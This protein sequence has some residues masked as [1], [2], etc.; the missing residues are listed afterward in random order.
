M[1]VAL[2]AVSIGYGIYLCGG[3][4]ES[5]HAV[6]NRERETVS[7]S[8]IDRERGQPLAIEAEPQ[9]SPPN[10]RSLL[11]RVVWVAYS[12]TMLELTISRNTAILEPGEMTWSFGQYL[13]LLVA[14]GSINELVHWVIARGRW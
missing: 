12:I 8:R 11:S 5:D 13:S 6:Y 9:H 4:G 2:I 7:L 3:S 1:T 10:P 14:L